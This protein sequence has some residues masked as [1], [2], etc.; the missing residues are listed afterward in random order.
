MTAI[1]S[2]GRKGNLQVNSTDGAACGNPKTFDA[3]GAVLAAQTMAS[4]QETN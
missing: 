4:I 3:A 2:G 1:L